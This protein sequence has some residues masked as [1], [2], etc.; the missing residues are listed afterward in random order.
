MKI[1]SRDTYSLLK[2]PSKNFFAYFLHGLDAGLIDER[3]QQ[4]ALLYSC[5]LDDP[6]SVSKLTGKDVQNEPALLS[7]ALNAM[8]LDSS[9]RTV[10]LSGTANELSAAV[11]TNINYLNANSRL[12][13]SAK[14]STNK[15]SLVSICEK[16][17][18]IA[19]IA[20]YP[21]DEKKVQKLISDILF[22]HR[23][24]IS[25]KLVKYLS[26]KLGIDRAINKNEIEKIA[27]FAA[28]TKTITK[29][30]IDI[31][32]GDNTSNILD[33]LIDNVFTG[34]TEELGILL[35]NSRLEGIQ[36]I[37]IIRFFQSYLK[38]LISVSASIETGLSAKAAVDNIRPPIYF[39][40]KQ[41]VLTHSKT[42]PIKRC[43]NLLER[44]TQLEKQYKE[45]KA[46]DP[47][48]FIGQSLLGVAIASS[49]H[50]F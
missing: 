9:L 16:H 20:C 12:I 25:P 26:E 14:E 11:K 19:S 7:D 40:R 4:I 1:S 33:K 47:Y 44:F 15:H 22:E 10:I 41:S 18:K 34:K 49:R 21:D 36:P 8:T 32:L 50:R 23:V 17:P 30:E 48:S 24:D 45:G 46:P 37:V 28:T 5:N 13:I 42:F 39:K 6:F 31:L 3:C 35:S 27:L 29:E 43:L 38:T 2:S